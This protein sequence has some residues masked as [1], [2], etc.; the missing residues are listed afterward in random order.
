MLYNIELKM[1]VPNLA[2]IFCETQLF[3]RQLK[4][5]GF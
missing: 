1:I 4:N 5:Q 3:V 2:K